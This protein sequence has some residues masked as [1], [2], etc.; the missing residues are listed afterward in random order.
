MTHL[1]A[2]P[3]PDQ[4]QQLS[5]RLMRE[6]RAFTLEELVAL[7]SDRKVR[8]AIGRGD[9][10]RVLPN[11]Y[12]AGIHEASFAA[13]A[14]AA[15]LWA[16][17]R[18]ALSGQ[19]ALF[20]WGLIDAPPTQIEIVL[21]HRQRPYPPAW[22]RVRRLSYRPATRR[23]GRLTVVAP[24]LAVILGFASLPRDRRGAVVFRAIGV[25]AT[26][27]QQLADALDRVPRCRGR[28]E[29]SRRID[30]A[31]HGSES[32]LEETSLRS[33]FN[34]REFAGLIRQH[35]VTVA[36]ESFRLD[37]YDPATMT[38]IETDGAA[39]HGSPEQRQRDVRRD[40]IL[41]GAGILTVRLTYDDVVNRPEAC[42][43]VVRRALES[44]RARPAPSLSSP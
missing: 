44:R 36:G 7:S 6:P 16:G 3:V 25:H 12:V 30:A 8:T 2:V 39:F 41:A 17:P 15:L 18:A 35:R 14:D 22:I 38:A 23:T 20:V 40:A 19:A 29:L 33:V 43:Q 31:L 1:R 11:T 26:T 13:R 32:Y 5:E 34:L 21:P 4:R 27:A 28:K 37:M 24:E 10:V 42:R 9:A